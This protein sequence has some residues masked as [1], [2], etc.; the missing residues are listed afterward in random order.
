LDHLL[1]GLLAQFANLN[2][3]QDGGD[4]ICILAEAAGTLY[5]RTKALSLFNSVATGVLDLSG[6]RD[7]STNVLPS[8]QLSNT[9]DVAWF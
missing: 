8:G 7:R 2:T 3:L 9:D 6:Y 4:R 5:R 1:A